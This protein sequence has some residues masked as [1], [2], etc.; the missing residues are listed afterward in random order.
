MVRTC[1]IWNRDSYPN[2]L[3]NAPTHPYQTPYTPHIGLP[4]GA[5][6]ETRDQRAPLKARPRLSRRADLG[7]VL[8]DY[9]SAA[10]MLR[11]NKRA[12]G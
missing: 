1:P 11:Y 9:V 8:A 7:R 2:C 10:L 5:E 12:V 3:C 6:H 4:E